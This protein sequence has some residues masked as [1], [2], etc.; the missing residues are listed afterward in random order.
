MGKVAE[1]TVELVDEIIDSDNKYE[2]KY[3]SNLEIDG[4]Q[5]KHIEEHGGEGKGEDFWVV[6]SAEDGVSKRFFE[7][8]GY[9]ASYHG[10]EWEGVKEVFP[11]LNVSFKW[12]GK[13]QEKLSDEQI[14]ELA[15]NLYR[16]YE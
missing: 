7:A 14:I 5:F 12:C 3:G 4:I 2:L 6:F 16:K 11:N 15:R 9:Y 10:A 1:L 8:Y 13:P